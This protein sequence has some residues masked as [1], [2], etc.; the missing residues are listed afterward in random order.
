[1]LLLIVMGMENNYEAYPNHNKLESIVCSY[2]IFNCKEQSNNNNNKVK[3]FN[4]LAL[5]VK[6]ILL[7]NLNHLC[8]ST[9]SI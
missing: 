4:I 8:D 2:F 6:L 9:I 3:L 1:M 7:I 5:Y